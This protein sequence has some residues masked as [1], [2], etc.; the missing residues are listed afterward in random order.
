MRYRLLIALLPI[1]AGAAWAQMPAISAKAQTSHD[2]TIT[3]TS[4]TLAQ[5]GFVAVHALDANGKLV[6]T[7]PLGVE[8]LAAGT[9]G[10]VTIQ[11]D[12]A[13]LEK[14]GYLNGE[15]TVVPM[16]HID[17]NRNGVYDFPDGP[18][19]PVMKNGGPLTA[20]VPYTLGPAL[21]ARDQTLANGAT[22]TIDA[23]DAPR[24][25][26]VAVHALDANG[27]LVLSPPLAVAKVKAGL[28]RYVHVSLDPALLK[29]YGYD[30]GSKRIVPMLHVDANH[31]GDYEFPGPDAPVMANGGPLVSPLVLAMP[32]M[33][34]P[35]VTVMSKEKLEVTATGLQVTLPAVTLTQPGF[36]VLHATKADGSLVPLPVLGWTKPLSAGRHANV[37]IRIRPDAAPVAG[38]KVIAMVHVDDGDGVYNFPASD[39]PY[40]VDGHPYVEAFTLE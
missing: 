17:A 36:V 5:D 19:A 11:L 9:H 35:S 23:V 2:F 18:D 3:I 33:G 40:L 13:L 37:I 25:G 30:A 29:K 15:K 6:L 12:P 21:E 14:Y 32:E 10:M 28:N 38:D 24:D 31:N 34:K 1:L 20:Q 8:R 7:P 39:P 22:V 4:V 16:V 27:K 26:F